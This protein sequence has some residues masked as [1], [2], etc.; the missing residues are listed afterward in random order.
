MS[1]FVRQIN[2]YPLTRPVYR[3]RGRSSH[4]QRLRRFVVTPISP[5]L[6]CKIEPVSCG[7]IKIQIK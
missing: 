5:P 7:N 4:P 2:E 3:R 1:N 6:V